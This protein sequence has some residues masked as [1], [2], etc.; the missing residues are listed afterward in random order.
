MCLLYRIFQCL[1]FQ[2]K[3]LR[4]KSNE[5][6]TYASEVTHTHTH[7][8]THTRT[9]IHMYI[10]INIQYAYVYICMLL[11]SCFCQGLKALIRELCTLCLSLLLDLEN[12]ISSD[13]RWEAV[14][15]GNSPHNSVFLFSPGPEIEHKAFYVLNNCSKTESQPII[16]LETFLCE[17]Y[18]PTRLL[19]S[20][21]QAREWE[22]EREER[23]HQGQGEAPALAT[24]GTPRVLVSSEPAVSQ[25]LSP[26]G[27]H[28]CHPCFS[29]KLKPP[30]THV[31][32]FHL[33][34]L[35]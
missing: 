28:S 31:P 29:E 11:L 22:G 10:C 2:S 5:S 7:T 9:H 20:W 3:I 26:S 1:K 21:K 32:P 24:T 14:D 30:L 16:C 19:L 15:K 12:C 35:M 34:T 13:F 8:H 6:I 27:D 25:A 23:K 18:I 4:Q 33:R 17:S